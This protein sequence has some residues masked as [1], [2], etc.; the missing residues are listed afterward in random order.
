ME[1]NLSSNS[2][3]VLACRSGGNSSNVG[4]LFLDSIQYHEHLGQNVTGNGA[5]LH[6][7]IDVVTLFKHWSV[8]AREMKVDLLLTAAHGDIICF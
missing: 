5:D 1:V 4:L 7:M 3:M 6:D 8:S 2:R